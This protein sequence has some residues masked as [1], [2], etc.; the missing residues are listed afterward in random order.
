MAAP[1]LATYGQMKAP[2]WQLL[3]E[4]AEHWAH[5]TN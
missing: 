5:Q 2:A 1:D 4:W 3:M